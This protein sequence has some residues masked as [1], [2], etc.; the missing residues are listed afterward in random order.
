M[1]NQLQ[2]M[3]H[4]VIYFYVH[5]YEPVVTLI[6]N[7]KRFIILAETVQ[8]LRFFRAPHLLPAV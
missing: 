8:L 2:N 5:L 1:R 7:E 6:E 3:P 4:S